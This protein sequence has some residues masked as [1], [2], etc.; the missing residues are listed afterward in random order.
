LLEAQPARLKR[1]PEYRE[2]LTLL[3][4]DPRLGRARLSPLALDLLNKPRLKP[5]FLGNFF[6]TYR[7]PKH[8]FFKVFLRLRWEYAH[9]LAAARL[10]RAARLEGIMAGY[11]PEARAFIAF[12]KGLERGRDPRRFWADLDPV[13]RTLTRARELAALSPEAWTRYCL[14]AIDSL[15]ARRPS[16]PLFPNAE[17][18]AL[19]ILGCLPDPRSLRA[20]TAQ[21]IKAAFRARSKEA[22]PDLGG[23]AAAFKRLKRARDFLLGSGAP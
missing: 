22:H 11:P 19:A 14:G 13:P 16:L 20:P 21:R 2:L 3:N 23:D 9:S 5:E 6:K 1:L 10:D 12:F 7:L 18:A 17:L 15:R 4:A 8:D